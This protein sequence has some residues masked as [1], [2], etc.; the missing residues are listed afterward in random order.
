LKTPVNL[1]ST[2]GVSE[3]RQGTWTM[4]ES[5]ACFPGL[6]DSSQSWKHRMQ[7]LHRPRKIKL[8]SPTFGIAYQAQDQDQ[9]SRPGR[10]ERINQHRSPS[11]Q[12]SPPTPHNSIHAN[13]HCRWL[14]GLV[15][16]GNYGATLS[17][18]YRFEHRHDNHSLGRYHSTLLAKLS[19]Y[20]HGYL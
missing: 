14:P 18:P 17:E 15:R 3:S 20:Y 12:Q 10:S 9:A 5:L 13:L 4:H 8:G 16:Y 2:C 11:L 7:A 6:I 19:R 1:Q